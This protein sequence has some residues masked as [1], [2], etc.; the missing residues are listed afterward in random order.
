[1]GQ[2]G[3]I[4]SLLAYAQCDWQQFLTLSYHKKVV[5]DFLEAH[6]NVS[7][8]PFLVLHFFQWLKLDL[9]ELAKLAC[10]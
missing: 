6:L 9:V 8:Q 5:K 1:L 2:I 3:I 7:K 4:L 10:D